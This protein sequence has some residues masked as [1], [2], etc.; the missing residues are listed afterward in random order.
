LRSRD[1]CHFFTYC[2]FRDF[3]YRL[4]NAAHGFVFDTITT[5]TFKE[6]N[7]IQ[8]P[9]NLRKEFENVTSPLFNRI[10]ANLRENRTL[11]QTR[12]LLL[13]KLMSGEISRRE[14]EKAVE[15]AA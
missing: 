11:A 14:T 2:W 6:A 3:V 13:P 10:L 9:P 12:D 7:V 15:A 1:N 5:N 4:V 8:P